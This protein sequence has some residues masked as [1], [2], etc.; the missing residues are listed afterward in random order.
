VFAGHAGQPQTET[1]P[2]AEPPLVVAGS[3]PTAAPPV[4]TVIVVVEPLVQEQ[5]QAGQAAPTGHSGQLQVQVP[6]PL[7]P[8]PVDTPAPV[9]VPVPHPPA[10]PPLPPVPPPPVPHWQSHGG[11]ASPGKQA[12]HPQVQVPPPPLPAFTA[13]GGGQ[14]HCT[15]GQAPF[16]GQASGCTQRQP[17]PVDDPRSKQKPPPPQSAPRGQSAGAAAVVAIADQAQAPFA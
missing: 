3:F 14:S 12:G 5:L 4:G 16:A 10:P 2:E 6:L 1:G 8:V 9:P 13:G 15:G 7:L 17:G 11:H